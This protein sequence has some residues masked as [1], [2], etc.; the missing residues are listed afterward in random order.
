MSKP[1]RSRVNRLKRNRVRRSVVRRHAERLEARILPGGFLDLLAG[2]AIASTYDLLPEEPGLLQ[3]PLL[4]EE[5]EVGSAIPR[6]AD[7]SDS[8]VPSTRLAEPRADS[9]SWDA[10]LEPHEER[11][12]PPQSDDDPHITRYSPTGAATNPFLAIPLV[13][14]FFAG[15]PFVDTPSIAIAPHPQMMPTT[16]APLG[17]PMSQLGASVGSGTGQGGV[18]AT[19][20]PSPNA[21]NSAAGLP[22]IPVAMLGEG[23]GINVPVDVNAVVASIAPGAD[24]G[25]GEVSGTGQVVTIG[26]DGQPT[27]TSLACMN[28]PSEAAP[29]VFYRDP[30]ASVDIYDPNYR[31]TIHFLDDAADEGVIIGTPG[32]DETGD[33]RLP[34]G[35]PFV[36]DSFTAWLEVTSYKRWYEFHR[37]FS[38]GNGNPIRDYDHHHEVTVMVTHSTSTT[39]G[40][41]IEVSREVSLTAQAEVVSIASTLGGGVTLSAEFTSEDTT[42]QTTTK[43][44]RV[45]AGACQIVDVYQQFEMVEVTMKYVYF[46]DQFGLG[47]FRTPNYFNHIVEAPPATVKIVSHKAFDKL[48]SR[49]ASGSI[50]VQSSP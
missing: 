20:S 36:D 41:T 37:V 34:I 42:S 8:L 15:N 29:Q 31:P 47:W 21:G 26:P 39:Y 14:A 22:A 44:E 18:P 46:E 30:A 19:A 33:F 9:A 38:R 4:A 25:D 49:S 11:A 13:D 24:A 35:M 12:A 43:D 6:G 48:T 50:V 7:R 1:C 16:I 45:L 23:E 5:I 40:A 10:G 17:S 27:I 3:V 2:A 32:T 28:L